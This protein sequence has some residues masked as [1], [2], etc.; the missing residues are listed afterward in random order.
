MQFY[1]QFLLVNTSEL[2]HTLDNFGCQ[3]INITKKQLTFTYLNSTRETEI[4]RQPAVVQFHPY[5]VKAHF[6]IT[7]L[8]QQFKWQ[9]CNLFYEV[10]LI[11]ISAYRWFILPIT[12]YTFH[13]YYI[14]TKPTYE[15]VQFAITAFICKKCST[16]GVES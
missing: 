12:A 5:E 10:I 11:C 6:K 9:L 2:Y 8:I 13:F 14:D 1:T 16:P 4:A 15:Y 3:N 7:S